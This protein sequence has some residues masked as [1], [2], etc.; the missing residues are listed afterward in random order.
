MFALYLGV[1]GLLVQT[2]IA[3]IDPENKVS[4]VALVAGVSA[5]F[6]TVFNPIGGTL[7]DR[8]RSRWGRRNP[9]ILG[10]AVAALATMLLMSQV[11]TIP[12]ILLG[13]S[14]AQAMMNLYQA[15]LTA[16]V[17]DRVPEERR[18]TASAVISVA[19]SI[20]IMIGTQVAAF[21]VASVSLG[22][23]VFGS[24]VVLGALLVVSTTHDPRPGEYE[25][26]ERP[27]VSSPRRSGTSSRPSPTATSCGS[28]S[29]AP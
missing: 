17:P 12:M 20:G 22:Y 28:S 10:G 29:A 13:W 5:I 21:F 2:Q 7:S 24:A 26:A 19:T 25:V 18:G 9:W 11:S 16:I 6:A 1:G 23:L 27:K 3:E 8:T 15:A 14:L 4:N